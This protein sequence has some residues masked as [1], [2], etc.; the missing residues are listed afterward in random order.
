MTSEKK[1]MLAGELYHPGDP[2]L[3]NE[4]AS[5]QSLINK[6]NSLI[7]SDIERRPATLTNLMGAVGERVTIRAPVFVDYGY[8]VFI[9]DD[10][11]LNFGCTFLDVCAIKIGDRCQIGPGVQFYAADHPLDP[12][13]RASGL[14]N[15]KPIEIGTNVWIGG[16][17]IILPGVS[18]GDNAIVGAGSVV[19]R[20]VAPGVTV[21]G[22]PASTKP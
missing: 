3:T 7:T 10:V 4:R 11:F 12:G 9:G 18:I 16:H 19:T 8:N 5:A 14:E 13:L 2:E 6:Y 21:M 17:A 15:G 20:D 22:N 1:K